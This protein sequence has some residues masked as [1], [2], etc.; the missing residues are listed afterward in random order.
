MKTPLTR[1]R[2]RNHLAY[3]WWKY[4]LLLV[5]AIFGWDIIYN[6]TRYRPPEEKKINLNVYVRS[7][8][9]ALDAYLAEINATLMPEMEE[10]SATY[11]VLEEMYGDMVFSAHMAAN[12]GDIYLLSRDYFQ[13]YASSGVYRALEDETEL[14]ATLEE[15]GIPLTQGWRALSS[16]SER[17]LYAIPCAN[18][19]S[20]AYF[21]ADPADCYLAVLVNNGNDANVLRFLNIFVSDLLQPI[22]II[23]E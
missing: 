19:P 6:I 14:L 2:L 5:I 12:D 16:T 15:A 20:S 3:S 22:E 10:M 23:E 13:R 1:Q 11:N 21:V 9:A 8:E 17:H 7:N 4:A 18:L